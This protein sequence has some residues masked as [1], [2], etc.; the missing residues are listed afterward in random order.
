MFL[1]ETGMNTLRFAYLVFH[2][3][4]YDVITASYRSSWKLTSV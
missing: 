3:R 1:D 4:L 2:N